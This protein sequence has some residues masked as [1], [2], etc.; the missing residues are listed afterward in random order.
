M[1]LNIFIFFLIVVVVF[2]L[3][4]LLRILCDSLRQVQIALQKSLSGCTQLCLLVDDK[5]IADMFV[6]LVS[7][8]NL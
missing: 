6:D 8:L 4:T 3:L 5:T 2:L 1:A 7:V